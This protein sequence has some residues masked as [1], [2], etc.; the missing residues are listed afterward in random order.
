MIAG[1]LEILVSFK[2]KVI[3]YAASKDV[4][5]GRGGHDNAGG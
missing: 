1:S 3:E 5:T 2:N 4:F